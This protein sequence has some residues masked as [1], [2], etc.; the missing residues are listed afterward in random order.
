VVPFQE[1]LPDRTAVETLTF[2]CSARRDFRAYLLTAAGLVFAYA[3]ATVDPASNC[4]ESGECAA[5]LVPVAFWVGVF[6]AIAGAVNL[7]RNPR[8]GSRVDL[9]GRLLVWWN[10]HLAPTPQRLPLDEV[11]AI[12]VD[13]RGDDDRVT[14]LDRDGRALPFPKDEVIPWPY[15][16]WAE[17]LARHFPHIRV[18][19]LR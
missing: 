13:T 16:G 4:S 6:V 12:R 9:A 1:R 15:A 5:W 8:R 14:L 18:D 7:W 11:A 10:D 17:A 2:A 3:G 19:I